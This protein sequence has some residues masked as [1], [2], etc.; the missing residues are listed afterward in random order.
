MLQPSLQFN[1]SKISGSNSSGVWE[2]VFNFSYTLYPSAFMVLSFFPIKNS[3][4][5]FKPPGIGNNE[6][7]AQS[8]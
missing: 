3:I 1:T 7:R 5:S 4:F 6:P 8:I 2:Y